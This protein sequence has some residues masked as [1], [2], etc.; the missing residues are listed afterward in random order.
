MEFANRTKLIDVLI[1]LIKFKLVKTVVIEFKKKNSDDTTNNSIKQD[2]SSKDYLI[3]NE[4]DIDDLFESIYTTIVLNKQKYL[5]KGSG[6][7]NDSAV[8][9]ISRYNPLAGSSYIR[10]H[11]SRIILPEKRLD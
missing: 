10:L 8:S 4:S 3:I 5:G 1:K 7:I 9:N 2:S 6:W 11:L